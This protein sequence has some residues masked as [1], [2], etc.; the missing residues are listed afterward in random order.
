MPLTARLSASV[1]PDVNVTSP[2]LQPSTWATVS[3]ATSSAV[4]AEPPSE[5]W[6]EGL[7]NS[8]VR[9]GH[10]ASSP[11][12][13]TGVVAAAS[14]KILAGSAHRQLDVQAEVQG[15]DGVRQGAD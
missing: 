7:P 12:R 11:S 8:P 13:R 2:G 4:E 5:W 6:L 10:M 3:R 9:K 1:P 14:R 15:G